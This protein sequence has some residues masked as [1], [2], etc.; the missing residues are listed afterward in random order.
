MSDAKS[1]L[2]AIVVGLLGIFVLV[3]G[4]PLLFKVL[5]IAL[6]IVGALV[7]LAIGLLYLAVALA[8]GYLLLVG[9]RAL[10]R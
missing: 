3:M 2:K 1:T 8:V 9:I 5:G 10:L 4:I 7:Q 6:G